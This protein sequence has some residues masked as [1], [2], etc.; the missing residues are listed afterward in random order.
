MLTQG[1]CE[2]T[3]SP[4]QKGFTRKKISSHKYRDSFFKSEKKPRRDNSTAV[5]SH[6][7]S[8]TL[9]E[10]RKD[11]FGTPITKGSRKHRVTF[12]DDLKKTNIADI[13]EIKEVENQ[14]SKEE[15][16]YVIK[17]RKSNEEKEKDDDKETI[18]RKEEGEIVKC[19]GCIIF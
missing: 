9:L 19:R 1:K 15:N 18:Q 16:K 17:Y 12:I 10:E 14:T 4:S 13:S 11:A 8:L 2:Y 5:I 6:R 7:S 3:R